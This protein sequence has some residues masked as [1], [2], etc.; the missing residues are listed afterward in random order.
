MRV[1]TYASTCDSTLSLLVVVSNDDAW[2][3]NRKARNQSW[4]V[5][6]ETDETIERN[7]SGRERIKT[8]GEQVAV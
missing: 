6:H 3:F 7:L 8:S 1:T 2:Y 4:Q 5:N